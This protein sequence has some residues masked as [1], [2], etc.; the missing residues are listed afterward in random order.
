[1][2]TI[3]TT[4][5][6]EATTN[7]QS[8]NADGKGVYGIINNSGQQAILKMNTGGGEIPLND[9]TFWEFATN[10][11]AVSSLI[12]IKLDSGTGNVDYII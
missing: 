2:N 1:M 11:G 3:R 6:L 7:Y 10:L 5:R 9:G 12:E 4:R 8:I